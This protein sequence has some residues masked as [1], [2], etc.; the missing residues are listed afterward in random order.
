MAWPHNAM[1]VF[2][3]LEKSNCRECGAPTCL[4]FAAAVFKGE[5][6]LGACPRL[7]A[8]ILSKY[9]AQAD[10]QA[11]PY[12]DMQAHLE[13]MRQEVLALDLEKT[14]QRVGGNCHRGRLTI[15]ILGKDFSV[16]A[17][18]VLSSDIHVH[19]WIA[20]PFFQY[21]LNCQGA[22]LAGKWMPLRELESGRDWANFFSH[23]CEKPLK[24]L[25]DT[26]TDLFEDM[27][28]LFNGK[29]VENHYQADISLV[30]HPLPRLPLL[31]CYWRPEDGMDS[32]LNIFFDAHAEKNLP[33]DAIYMLGTGLLRM[34]EKIALRHGVRTDRA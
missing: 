17:K 8:Q 19:N 16:D 7:D 11:E 30:L 31:I 6:S 5:Q 23:R 10:L 32:N 27:I 3:L 21:L 22:P 25:A 34:F 2:K 29:Q 13:Q 20:L 18:G 26:Y 24:K 4:A 33:I 14:A 15:K 12:D 1:E 9:G 28:H